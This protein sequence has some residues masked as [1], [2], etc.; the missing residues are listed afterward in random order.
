M[1][2]DSTDEY[3]KNSLGTIMN[4]D[5]D[6]HFDLS[7]LEV[8]RKESFMLNHISIGEKNITFEYDG[9]KTVYKFDLAL[10]PLDF[11]GGE[12][13]KM[14]ILSMIKNDESFL[15]SYTSFLRDWKIT[16]IIDK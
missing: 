4:G 16:T 1:N 9:I 14:D 13:L 6:N 11:Y 10:D 7:Q 3:L 2:I 8:A 15:K 12:D 5:W